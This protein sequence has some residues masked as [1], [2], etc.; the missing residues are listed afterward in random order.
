MA[1]H[2]LLEE[3]IG[4]LNSKQS[5]LL[6]AARDDSDRLHKIIEDL[7]DM[8]RLES[9]RVEMDLQPRPAQELIMEAL[10]AQEA[11]FHDRGITVEIDVQPDVPSVLADPARIDHVF[12]NLLSNALKFTPPGGHV[13]LS[14]VAEDDMVRF[15]VEDTGP[16]IAAEHLTRIFDRFYRVTGPGQPGGAGLGLAI[17]KEI[18]QAHGGTI[19][20]ESTLGQG[21]RFSFTLRRGD[22][23][24]VT[25]VH[26]HGTVQHVD[27]SLVGG[28]S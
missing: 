2:L 18:V 26:P 23:L 12:S 21:T 24:A 28:Q 5:E 9:G 25:S 7:L 17:A 8:G 11:S 1:V 3:R 13:K 16:G 20:V 6:I 19:G 27:Q 4:S 14:A 22:Q 15:I 10:T